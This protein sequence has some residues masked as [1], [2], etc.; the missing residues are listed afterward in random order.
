MFQ[1]ASIIFVFFKIQRKKVAQLYRAS[2]PGHAAVEGPLPSLSLCPSA[3]CTATAM[4]PAQV[5][6]DSGQE[7]GG[8]RPGPEGAPVRADWRAAGARETRGQGIGQTSHLAPGLGR[9]RER[10]DGPCTGEAGSVV[11]EHGT[12]L[13]AEL[14]CKP[15][16][17]HENQVLI[18]EKKSQ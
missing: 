12:L 7:A 13:S 8:S 4:G 14:F 17:A 2:F 3:T 16:I 6:L 9:G 11:T 5:T 15:N 1:Q 18:R 10:A